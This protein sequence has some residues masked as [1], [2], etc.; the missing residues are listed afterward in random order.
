MIQFVK[1]V[2]PI[3]N[4]HCKAISTFMDKHHLPHYAIKKIYLKTLQGK[5]ILSILM[6]ETTRHN[7]F[8]SSINTCIDV[9]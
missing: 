3:V 9:V 4:P 1:S 8:G 6:K 7:N 2:A 5:G